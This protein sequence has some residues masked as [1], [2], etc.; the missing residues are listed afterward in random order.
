MMEVYNVS[1]NLQSYSPEDNTR[2]DLRQFLYN[3]RW[4]YQFRK[5]DEL[6]HGLDVKDG[7]DSRNHEALAAAADGVSGMKV[8]ASNSVISWMGISA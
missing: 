5:I 8:A 4:P 7:Q 2:F 3:T 6:V 1:L